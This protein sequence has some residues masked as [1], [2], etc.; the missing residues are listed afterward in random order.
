MRTTTKTTTIGGIAM[1][2]SLLASAE[3]AHAAKLEVPTTVTCQFVGVDDSAP[4]LGVVECEYEC[5]CGNNTSLLYYVVS[6][7][8]CDSTTE[9]NSRQ[10]P[11]TAH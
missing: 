3:C 2:L 10:C 5:P 8:S 7:G 6:G 11:V 9:I 1:A 4:S